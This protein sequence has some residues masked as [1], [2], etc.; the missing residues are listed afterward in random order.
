MT[1]ELRILFRNYERGRFEKLNRR[2]RRSAR[3]LQR[4]DHSQVLRLFSPSV[5][6]EG[7]QEEGRGSEGVGSFLCISL[8]PHKCLTVPRTA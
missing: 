3:V 4:D 7:E 6:W 5:L 2:T 1:A 8:I